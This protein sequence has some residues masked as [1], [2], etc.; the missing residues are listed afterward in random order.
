MNIGIYKIQNITDN[1][2]Y[3]G[4]SVDIKS[5]QYKHF[6]MLTLGSHYNSHL[7]SSYNKFGK[8]SFIFEILELCNTEYLVS[9]ENKYIDL[10]NSIDSTYGYNQAKVNEFRR[11]TFNADV[12]LKLSKYNLNKNKNFSTYSLKNINTGE[13]FIFDSLV[14]G[15]D[16]LINNGFTK[17]K[18]RS[19][20]MKIS[21][22]LRG[23]LVNNGYKGSIRKTCY[24][25]EFKIIN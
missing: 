25:H 24:K 7:Q 5:R 18:P 22:S 6:W 21:N 23:K 17:G 15:A 9:L 12:K 13:I 3:I 16:Y 20:R 4:S 11:N 14:G 2:V 10:Y 8:D 19:V 1:K